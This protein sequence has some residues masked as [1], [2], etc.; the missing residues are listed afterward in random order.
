MIHVLRTAVLVP[1]MELPP[2][3]LAIL[4]RSRRPVPA[5]ASVRAGHTAGTGR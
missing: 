5:V 2:L 1:L 4:S 3:G